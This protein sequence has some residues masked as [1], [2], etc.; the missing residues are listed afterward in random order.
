MK[1]HVKVLV[2]GGGAVGTGIAYHL[3]KAGWDTMLVERDGIPMTGLARTALDVGREHGFARGVVSI[4]AALRRAIIE[5][6]GRLQV[7]RAFHVC[8]KL[9]KQK[10]PRNY[11]DRLLFHSALIRAHRPQPCG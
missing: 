7:D 6:R 1:T 11:R 2:V 5:N 9:Q 4:D 3:A 8:R 10:R